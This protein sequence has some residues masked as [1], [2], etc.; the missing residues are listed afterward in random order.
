ML[1]RGLHNSFNKIVLSAAAASVV[2]IWPMTYHNQATG[3]AQTMLIV[4]IL[5]T[6][7]MAVLLARLGH[8]TNRK[9]R[10]T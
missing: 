9:W 10:K 6:T 5:V 8:L 4:E 3:A 7:S 1:P 2:I